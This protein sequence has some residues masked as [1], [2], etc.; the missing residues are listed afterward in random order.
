MCID[1]K[2]LTSI[3]AG[4][5]LPAPFRKWTKALILNHSQ[6][7]VG[8]GTQSRDPPESTTNGQDP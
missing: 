4:I 6:S 2:C 7:A 5:S 1:E 8:K 3:G